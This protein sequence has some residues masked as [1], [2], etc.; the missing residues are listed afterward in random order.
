MLALILS[1]DILTSLVATPVLIESKNRVNSFKL[2]IEL[3]G[4]ETSLNSN[5]N[6]K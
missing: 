1:V 2:L 6:V 5:E 4:P 3:N